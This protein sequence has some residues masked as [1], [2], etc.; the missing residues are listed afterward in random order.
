MLTTPN[1]KQSFLLVELHNRF[2]LNYT[3]TLIL[4][5]ETFRL[6][7]THT[8]LSLS[9]FIFLLY[10]ICIIIFWTD[11]SNC[12]FLLHFIIWH[13]CQLVEVNKQTFFLLIKLHS[14]FILELTF[15]SLLIYKW[16]FIF[17]PL[18]LYH[19]ILNRF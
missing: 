13:K 12:F 10:N 3:F 17:L 8:I 18:A 15:C 5:F 11:C 19:F 14:R 7:I 16:S 9:S 6:F 4:R 1:G 2:I